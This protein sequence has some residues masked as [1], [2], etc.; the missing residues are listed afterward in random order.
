MVFNFSIC[1]A[2]EFDSIADTTCGAAG[3]TTTYNL[4]IRCM[5]SILQFQFLGYRYAT[6]ATS[7]EKLHC[8]ARCIDLIDYHFYTVTSTSM[9]LAVAALSDLVILRQCP[10]RTLNFDSR[11]RTFPANIY[12]V[13]GSCTRVWSCARRTSSDHV[14][15]YTDTRARPVAVARPHDLTQIKPFSWCR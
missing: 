9:A 10:V 7:R 1:A 6:L 13:F 5:C 3:R 8:T 11:T 14:P 12:I 4:Q 2:R 15:Y